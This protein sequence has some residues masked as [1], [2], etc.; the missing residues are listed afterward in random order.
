MSLFIH[1]EVWMQSDIIS[2]MFGSMMLSIFNNVQRYIYSD[3]NKMKP[4]KR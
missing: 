3:S 2:I 4:V 1:A